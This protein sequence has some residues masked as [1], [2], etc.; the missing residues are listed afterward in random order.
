MSYQLDLKVS[1]SLL[2]LVSATH[3]GA[4]ICM[5]FVAIPM[6]Y[7]LIIIIMVLCS[8]VCIARRYVFLLSQKSIVSVWH[9]EGWNWVL[10]YKSGRVIEVKL[11]PYSV[12]S[13]FFIILN[14]K[15]RK[16]S[17]DRSVFICRD[18]IDFAQLKRLRRFLLQS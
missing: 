2:F 12:L 13:R 7:K 3:I 14:F 18:I 1:R 15:S 8:Y 10:L 6:I 5:V 4:I 17:R 9:K 16:W 11:Q